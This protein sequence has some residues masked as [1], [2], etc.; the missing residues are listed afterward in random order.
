MYLV[1]FSNFQDFVLDWSSLGSHQ[2]ATLFLVHPVVIVV[3][4]PS[5]WNSRQSDS[6]QNSTKRSYLWQI[7]HIHLWH[8]D[9]V[10]AFHYPYIL[11]LFCQF[12]CQKILQL[13]EDLQLICELNHTKRK[14][15]KKKTTLE[16]AP[17]YKFFYYTKLEL[18]WANKSIKPI[19]I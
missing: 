17:Q 3:I 2:E 1:L 6:S 4:P 10:Q 5:T 16:G 13:A 9:P 19:N 8:L 14:Q 7:S 15:T 11:L 18:K 12:L